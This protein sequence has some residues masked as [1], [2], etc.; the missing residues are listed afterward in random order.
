VTDMK[1]FIEFVAKGLVDHP[2]QV[3]IAEAQGDDE[4]TLVLELRCNPDDV[5][6]I[7]GRNGR[8]IKALRTLLVT[9]AARAGARAALEIAE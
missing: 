5:G 7:I 2:D 9:A 8:T 3:Q 6:K 4:K 1:A